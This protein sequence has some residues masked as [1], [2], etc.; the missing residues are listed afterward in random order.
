MLT[1][2]MDLS[3]LLA[4]CPKGNLVI[5]GKRRSKRFLKKAEYYIELSN[6][7]G[8]KVEIRVNETTYGS[9]DPDKNPYIPAK[10]A[11]KLQIN[12]RKRD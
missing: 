12:R 11:D 9:L 6:R 3:K 2:N 8:K 5:I 4:D 10:V 7:T 1:K